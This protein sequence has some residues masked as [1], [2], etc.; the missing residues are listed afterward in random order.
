MQIDIIRHRV[1]QVTLLTIPEG[2]CFSDHGVFMRVQK[3]EEWTK[4]EM[5]KD[6]IPCVNLVDG[7]LV[8]KGANSYVQPRR[9]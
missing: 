1:D 9:S 5:P 3:P 4:I 7:R 2:E 8:S 6:W